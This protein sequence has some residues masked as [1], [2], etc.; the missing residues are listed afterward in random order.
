[1]RETSST[2][3][4]TS[5]NDSVA[6]PPDLQS[7]ESLSLISGEHESMTANNNK[8]DKLKASKPSV[9][10]S[11]VRIHHHR[12]SLGDHPDVSSGIPLTLAWEYDQSE[13]LKVDDIV[14]EKD[15][16]QPNHSARVRRIPRT[17]RE[18]IAAERHSRDSI[19]LAKEQVRELQRS[20]EE[21]Q[22]DPLSCSEV[23][24]AKKASKKN[25]RRGIL[26]FLFRKRKGEK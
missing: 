5:N 2:V 8:T 25:Q 24:A 9:G 11:T 20:R 7:S 16:V 4:R 6:I 15:Q 17:H 12:L 26:G 3:D 21:S 14:H 1:M 10:F 23:C 18:E 22:S 13:T 19:I